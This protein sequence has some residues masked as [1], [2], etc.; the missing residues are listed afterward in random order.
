MRPPTANRWP[1][2]ISSYSIFKVVSFRDL[3]RDMAYSL[4]HHP[5]YALVGNVKLPTN[6]YKV[7]ASFLIFKHKATIFT[8]CF[9]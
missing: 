3:L 1:L 4:D 7:V 6:G 5:F 2:K 9:N 8:L